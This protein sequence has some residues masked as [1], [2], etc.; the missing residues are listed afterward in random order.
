[1]NEGSWPRTP[2]VSEIVLQNSQLLFIGNS[3]SNE[4]VVTPTTSGTRSGASRRAHDNPTG[5]FSNCASINEFEKS[6]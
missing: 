1:M 6:C 3:F 2:S 4:P 5:R